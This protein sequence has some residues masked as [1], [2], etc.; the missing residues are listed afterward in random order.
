M[1]LLTGATPLL[2]ITQDAVEHLTY[3]QLG[4][5]RNVW[6]SHSHFGLM[7]GRGDMQNLRHLIHRLQERCTQTSDLQEQ[8]KL[9]KRLGILLGGTAVLRVSGINEIETKRRKQLAERTVNA[10]RGVLQGGAVPGGG[11]ALLRVAH[12][13]KHTKLKNATE[14]E[15]AAISILSTALQAPLRVLACNAGYE[16]G[17]VLSKLE[18][19]QFKQAFD[20]TQGQL[21]DFKKGYLFD[22]AETV[23]QVISLTI[24][25]VSLAL[26][27][28]VLLQHDQPEISN[29]P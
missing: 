17:Y 8:T 14:E 26:T 25:A 24:R 29:L 12:K 1:A 27:I 19:R 21:V 16:A 10:M 7:G 13:L 23:K 22:S 11:V 3:E 15:L 18:A 20:M 6:V 9:Q 4:Q 5:A 28:D 2:S